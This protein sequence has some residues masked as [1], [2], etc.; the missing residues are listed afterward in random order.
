MSVVLQDV[1]TCSFRSDKIV[2]SVKTFCKNQEIIASPDVKSVPVTLGLCRTCPYSDSPPV[3]AVSPSPRKL[4]GIEMFNDIYNGWG[5][6]SL[7][8]RLYAYRGVSGCEACIALA[9]KMNQMGPD[10]CLR[11][12]EMLVSDILPRFQL[13]WQDSRYRHSLK[14]EYA[15]GQ[16]GYRLLNKFANVLQNFDINIPENLMRRII[17]RDIVKCIDESRRHQ[18]ECP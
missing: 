18:D 2:N 5:V 11:D 8:L 10:A 17:R 4:V 3:N 13:W 9:D 12:L 15:D 16:L 6:G 1:P 7:L 14:S